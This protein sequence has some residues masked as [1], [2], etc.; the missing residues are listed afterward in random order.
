[1]KL[2][3]VKARPG[4]AGCFLYVLLL[5]AGMY[6]Q[7]AYAQTPATR[8]PSAVNTPPA[9]NAADSFEPTLKVGDAAPPIVAEKWIKGSPVTQF[10][11]GQLYIIEFW[12]TWC[13]PCRAAM[14][15]LSEIARRYK[16]KITVIGFNVLELDAAKNKDGDYITKVSNFVKNLGDGMDYTVAADV[17]AG[18]M[19][20]TWLSAA[21]IG[22]IP[23]SFIIDGNGKIAWIGHPVVLDDAIALVMSGQM[24]EKKGKALWPAFRAKN[25]ERMAIAAQV[26]EL[27]KKGETEKAVTLIDPLIAETVL[28]KSPFVI[29]KYNLLKKLDAAKAGKYALELMKTYANDP[30][31]LQDVARTIVNNDNAEDKTIALKIMEQ[32]VKKSAPDD[33]FAHSMLADIYYKNGNYKKAVSTQEYVVRLLEDTS[34]VEQ[35][36]E[37]KDK[38]KQDLKKYKASE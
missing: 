13:G 2:S 21:G 17:R 1:M 22:G 14:P 5:S 28:G 3:F 15:H 33:P 7:S 24:D 12:A 10:A 29:I 23:S 31:T 25:N 20:K 37:V 9:G 11:P 16:G 8:P 35:R 18:T 32:A 4:R 38:V 26:E 30:L 27:S 36:Q 19:H 34:L 6:G